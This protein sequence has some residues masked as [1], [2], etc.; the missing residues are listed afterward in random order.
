MFALAGVRLFHIFTQSILRYSDSGLFGVY[1]VCQPEKAPKLW[2]DDGRCK[3]SF[4][5]VFEKVST[6]SL[7][8]LRSVW[9]GGDF[10][11]SHTGMLAKVSIGLGR[12]VWSLSSPQ[13]SPSPDQASD[14]AMA[15]ASALKGLS[16][17]SKDGGRLVG[18]QGL[19]AWGG[20]AT[21][22]FSEAPNLSEPSQPHA[23]STLSPCSGGAGKG[24]GD[25]QGQDVPAGFVPTVLWGSVSDA[26]VRNS[27][28]HE[29]KTER[30]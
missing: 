9:G 29:P 13:S 6:A 5:R 14:M 20:P 15:M 16:S 7:L 27:T 23:F 28:S 10:E 4:G 11:G 12:C 8:A 19:Q 25:S 17:V 2:A 22:S 24:Q 30:P 1:G 21:S 3:S 26:Q 18:V